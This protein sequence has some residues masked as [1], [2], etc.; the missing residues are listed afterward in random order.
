MEARKITVIESSKQS[1]KVILSEATTL[2]ELK[3]DFMA[4]GIDC[5]N[6]DFYEGISK[7]ELKSDSSILPTNVPYKGTTTNELPLMNLYSC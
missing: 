7:T 5:T 4:N 6:M 2:G 3:A 1:K